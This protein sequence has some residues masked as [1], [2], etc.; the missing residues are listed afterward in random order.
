[1]NNAPPDSEPSD[2]HGPFGLVVRVPTPDRRPHPEHAPWTGAFPERLADFLTGLIPLFIA[3]LAAATDEQLQQARDAA[4]EQI[5]NH[6]DDL[7][8]GG[9]H[10]R[11]SRT[12][13]AKAF[14]LLARAEGG[15]TAL[16]VHACTAVHEGCPGLRPSHP[17]R[18]S[19][20]GRRP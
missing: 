9:E 19:D 16:G 20:S 4:L 12:A 7:Q 6:G 11:S 17:P 5:A 8:F 18:P 15:V 14:A 3:E 13:L 2:S 10:R 1:M